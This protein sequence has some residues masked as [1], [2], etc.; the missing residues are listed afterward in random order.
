MYASNPPSSGAHYPRWA[1]WGTHADPVPPP[2]FV[3]NL[4]HGGIVLLY[5]CGDA[6]CAEASRKFLES[7]AATLPTDPSCT[8]PVRVRVVIAPDATIPAPL[9]AAAWG[10]T[11]TSAC[12]DM[13]TLV[14]FV[15]AHYGQGPEDTCANG[16]YPP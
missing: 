14:D 16:S 4:E 8:P 7:V 5:K 6:A 12:A 9:A 15:R 13:Q 2:Y 11:Y 3:H 1:S 10:W